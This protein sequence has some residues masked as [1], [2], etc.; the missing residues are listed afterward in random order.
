[1]QGS[2]NEWEEAL[3]QDEPWRY[4]PIEKLLKILYI[5]F[6][7]M[8]DQLFV[9]FVAEEYCVKLS[10]VQKRKTLRKRKTTAKTSINPYFNESFVF[11]AS[12]EAMQVRTGLY[13]PLLRFT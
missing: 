4:Y 9:C 11:D 8:T 12:V 3:L 6:H 7:S 10:L 13:R 5:F 2:G 1:M